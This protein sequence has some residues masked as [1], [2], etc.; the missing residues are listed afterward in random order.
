MEGAQ[1]LHCSTLLSPVQASLKLDVPSDSGVVTIRGVSRRHFQKAASTVLPSVA[2]Q[3][4][5]LRAD[6][7]SNED[8]QEEV[9]Y[10]IG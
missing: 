4:S 9:P 5:A 1:D 3:L 2:G 10:S 8:E 6:T 7:V